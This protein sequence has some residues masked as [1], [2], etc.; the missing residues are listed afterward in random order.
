M[1][2]C[3]ISLFTTRLYL[4]QSHFSSIF[5]QHLW[6]GIE[7]L[8]ATVN[9]ALPREMAGSGWSPACSSKEDSTKP[10]ASWHVLLSS[11]GGENFSLHTLG[12]AWASSQPSSS[13]G[14]GATVHSP[15]SS[16]WE[17]LDEAEIA[18]RKISPEFNNSW[19]NVH[20]KEMKVLSRQMMYLLIVW[21]TK[22]CEMENRLY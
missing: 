7:M 22:C 14:T 8:R 3:S 17:L 6:R 16:H 9:C 10:P 19:G 11:E 4:K 15:V 5:R 18:F 2:M 20:Q 13:A 12:C 21:G 1:A